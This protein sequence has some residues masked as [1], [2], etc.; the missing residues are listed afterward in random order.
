MGRP[1]SE[2]TTV[3]RPY[4]AAADL[5]RMEETLAHAYAS[6]SLRVGD[7]SWLSRDHTHRELALDIHL[8]EDAAGQLVAWTYFRS[9]GEF[10]VFIVPGTRHADDAALADALL[11]TIEHAG[12]TSLAA[13]DPPVTLVTY[14]IDTARSAEDRTL[15]AALDRFGYQPDPSE[16]SSGVL[17]RS[18]DDLPAVSL[19]PGYHSG[20]VS[21]PALVIGRV[22]AHRAA[23]A[24]SDLSVKR[25]Q[26][27]QRTWAYRPE[28]D[29]VVATD[30]GAVVA[31]CTAWFDAHNRAGLL[32]P[33]GTHPAHQQRGLARAVCLDALHAL[34]ALGAS[35]A[36]VAYAS[37]AGF[38]T[39][40]SAGFQPTPRERVFSRALG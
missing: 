10:N 4:A 32:E 29:R 24:P 38:A 1:I 31:F 12:R 26:R 17:A 25:Y 30:T 6:T 22:E 8:W 21:T 3:E 7:L 14:A 2:L 20:W 16:T 15:A 34:R 11:G 33:V 35:R 18:L 23:F 9:N 37:P 19:P 5:R 27:V 36:Q 13:G 39:Y 28:L 40:T